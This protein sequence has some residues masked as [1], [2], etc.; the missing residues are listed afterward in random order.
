MTLLFVIGFTPPTDS[1]PYLSPQPDSNDKPLPDCIPAPDGSEELARLDKSKLFYHVNRLTNVQRL[2]IP[3]SVAPDILAI[4]H[5]E[6][7]PRFSRCYKIIACSWFIHGLTKLLRS[8]ICYCPQCL[9]L[10]TRRHP[11]YG[12]LQPMESPPIPFF[13]LTLDFMLVLLLSKKGFN[14]IMSV[15]CKFLKQVILVEGAYTW[16]AEQ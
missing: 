7:H 12:S 15:M 13:P 3:L 4:A 9:A 14:T 5:G 11:P 6:G 10:Q 16:S 1:D 8:F 2:C